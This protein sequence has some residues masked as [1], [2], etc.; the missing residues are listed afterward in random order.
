[1]CKSF[2]PEG[3]DVRFAIEN[4]AYERFTAHEPSPSI[5]VYHGV[6]EYQPAG[7]VLD[8]AENGPVWNYLWDHPNT[9][10]PAS[11]ADLYKWARQAVEGLE[12]A[13]SCDVLH[14]DIHCSNFL[15]DENLN[16]KVADFAESAIDGGS[17]ILFYRT[18]HCLP[19]AR[20]ASVESEIFALG[21]ALYF[22]VTGHDL[23]PELKQEVPEDKAE[24]KRRL[25]EGKF[26]PTSDLQI[27]GS[28]VRKCWSSEYSNMAEVSN[29]IA[30]ESGTLT[31]S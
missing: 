19:G 27:L 25:R 20:R 5:L 29:E 11:R 18:T 24:I 28:V 16:L 2:L 12:F 31:A 15:F 14:S 26:P 3:R 9:E 1:M 13:H 30:A 6:D 10:E 17:S 23:F 4:E 21:S 22:M 8:L 7:L